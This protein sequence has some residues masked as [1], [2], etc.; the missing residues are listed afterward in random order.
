MRHRWPM[1]SLSL[2]EALMCW[3]MDAAF[4]A[5]LEKAKQAEKAQQKRADAIHNLMTDANTR[6]ETTGAE[7]ASIEEVVPAK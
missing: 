2:M 7:P 6:T 4:Y 1:P 5:E 3:E